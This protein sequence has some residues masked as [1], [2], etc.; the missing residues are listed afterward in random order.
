MKKFF[1][2]TAA[3]I[4]SISLFS[5]GPN[6]YY[7]VTETRSGYV[8]TTE[9]N[10]GI[11]LGDNSANSPYSKYNIG[12]TNISAYQLSFK[13]GFMDNKLLQMGGGTGFYGYNEGAT[14]P[15]FADFRIIATGWE[16]EPYFYLQG[17]GLFNAKEFGSATR[18]FGNGGGGIRYPLNDKMALNLGLGLMVQMEPGGFRD[19]F[20]SIKLG[21]CILPGKKI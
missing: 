11:G 5:R 14:I 3:L 1:T 13:Q 2:L 7:T 21:F 10:S 19:S 6:I 18:M 12:I 4:M 15:L 17:G 8:N 16:I 20:I 9:I